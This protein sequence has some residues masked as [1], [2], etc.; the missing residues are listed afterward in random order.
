MPAALAAMTVA[1]GLMVEPSVPIP[2]PSSTVA[3][4]TNGSKRAAIMT[5]TSSV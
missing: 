3:A 5:G 2:A 4:A 1:K